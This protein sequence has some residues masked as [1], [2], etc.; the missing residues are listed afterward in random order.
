ML[1]GRLVMLL[2]YCDVFAWRVM[3]MAICDGLAACDAVG[4]FM[5]LLAE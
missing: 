2:L 4:W 1:L 3:L 5:M